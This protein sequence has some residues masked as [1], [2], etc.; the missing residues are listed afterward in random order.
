[1]Y[2]REGIKLSPY[3]MG[4]G[5]EKNQRASTQNVSGAVGLAKAMDICREKM[6]DEISQQMRLRNKVVQGILKNIEGVKL[7]GHPHQR[8]PNNAHF[9]FEKIESESLLMSLDMIGIAASMGSACTAGSM[10]PSHVLKAIG[11]PEEWAHGSLR[12]SIGRWTTDEDVDY[13]LQELPKIVKRL[14]I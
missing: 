4:G 12:I 13:L 3:L 7:N 11:L 2:V 6:S 10:E 14:R 5:Q 9:S 1:L 8:L